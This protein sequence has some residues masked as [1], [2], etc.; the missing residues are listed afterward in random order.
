VAVTPAP[1]DIELVSVGGGA[2]A[3]AHRPKVKRLPA[4]RDAGVTHLVTLLS[5]REGALS[6]G[7]AARAAGLEWVWVD[8]PNGQQPPPD[9]HAH[10]LD[11]LV[12]LATLLRDGANVVVHCS[13]GI[14]RTGM[15]TYALLRTCG[16]DGATALST[17]GRLRTATSE[18]VG[19][20]RIMWAEDLATAALNRLR[21]RAQDTGNQVTASLSVAKASASE[22]LSSSLSG[23]A[24]DGSSTSSQD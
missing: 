2:L 18:G 8:L 22:T 3:I 23:N 15:F 1:S 19:E 4:M 12:T 20:Q 10:V 7:S 14:H 13:A 6:V 11:A 21:I 24:S 16:L 5:K 17:L 9:R